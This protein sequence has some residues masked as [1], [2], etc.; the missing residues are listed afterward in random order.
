[1]TE[2]MTELKTLKDLEQSN[3]DEPKYVPEFITDLRQE[4]IKHIKD[5]QNNKGQSRP[6]IADLGSIEWIK[7]FFNI[8]EEDLI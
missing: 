6:E 1:M 2:T 7:Y 8:T 4:A 5:I 3:L